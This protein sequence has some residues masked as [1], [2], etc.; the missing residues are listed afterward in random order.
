MTIKDVLKKSENPTIKYAVLL[1]PAV[2]GILVTLFSLEKDF[3]I[4]PLLKDELRMTTYADG[5]PPQ[6]FG[7]SKISPYKF[8]DDTLNY[9]YKLG[10]DYQYRYAGISVG[11]VEDSSFINL[12]KYDYIKIRMKQTKEASAALFVKIYNEKFTTIS[13][14]MTHEFLSRNIT[15]DTGSISEIV[16]YFDEFNHPDWWLEARELEK[17]EM[18]DPDF[19]KVISLQIQNGTRYS[20]DTKVDVQILEISAGKDYSGRYKGLAGFILA[21]YTIVLLLFLYMKKSTDDGEKKVVI[22][23]EKLEVENDL[24][25]DTKRITDTIAKSYSDPTFSVDKLSKEAGI[26][27]SKIPGILKSQFGMNFKQYLNSIRINEAKRLLKET[28]NQI[29][30]IAYTVGYNNIP[31]FNRTFKQLEGVSPKEYRKNEPGEA[32]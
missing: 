23:Y 17:S 7:N 11:M 19:S 2:I 31:H 28:D 18:K 22:S 32:S 6:T 10:K 24:D 14:A 4:Y 30:N 8:K 12:A 13:D 21:Y 5:T 27:A 3:N 20:L 1:F 29:V 26:S 15:A 9:T 16:V 25:Q